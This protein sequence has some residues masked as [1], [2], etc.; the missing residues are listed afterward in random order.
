[1]Q[2]VYEKFLD[3]D[4]YSS[5]LSI[6]FAGRDSYKTACGSFVSLIIYSFV[7]Y[8]AVTSGLHMIHLESPTIKT[9]E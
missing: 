8:L 1:M 3:F 9:Y 2:F 4:M 7:G 5:P 6:M